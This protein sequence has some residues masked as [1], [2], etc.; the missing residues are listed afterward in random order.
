MKRKATTS[1]RFLDVR[2]PSEF[3]AGALPHSI[4]LPILLDDERKKVGAC[5]KANG[6]E[7]AI[8]L[9]H[10]LVVGDLRAARIAAWKACIE[11]NPSTRIICARGGLRSK[12]AAQ[13]L[14]D[15]GI[16][17]ERVEGGYKALRNQCLQV[18]D[19]VPQTLS[20]IVLGGR[21]GSGKTEMI[22]ERESALDLEELAQHRGSAFGAHAH[23][24][25]SQA[26]FENHLAHELAAF[27]PGQQVVIEDESRAIGSRS[28]PLRLYEVMGQAP[29]VVLEASR[30]ERASRI[31]DEYVAT[32]GK[33]LT[34]E[35]LRARYLASLQR[36][37]KRLGGANYARIAKEIS[38]AFDCGVRDAHLVWISS[39]L[40]SY[41]D[42]MY[43]HG[44]KR[45]RKRI[46]FRGPR[47]AVRQWL[48]TRLN[49]QGKSGTQPKP[50]AAH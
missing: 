41:Y 44:L 19:R 23:P 45:K 47:D 49:T 36:I 46:C 10:A 4:N 14:S 16:H 6:R 9:G 1:T 40:A 18:I 29:V 7:A 22:Q 24:Q 8:K 15:A 35:G 13:W 27:A 17:L 28:I 32:A 20:P 12:I 11:K 39:L 25:P 43:D 33:L 2:S 26:T 21:T 30:D 3:D 42:P 34:P 31:F 48:T 5:Y 50:L 37:A 38:T